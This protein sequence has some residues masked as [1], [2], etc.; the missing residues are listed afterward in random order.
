MVVA[1]SGRVVEP[2]SI[3]AAYAAACGMGRVGVGPGGVGVFASATNV[4]ERGQQ[5]GV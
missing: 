3:G 2:V 5:P 1:G 4:V